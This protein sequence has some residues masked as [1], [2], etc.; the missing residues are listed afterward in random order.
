[1]SD[2]AI[3]AFQDD[4]SFGWKNWARSSDGVNFSTGQEYNTNIGG[5][6]PVG[7]V[8]ALDGNYLALSRVG[9]LY[10]RTAGANP[11]TAVRTVPGTPTTFDGSDCCNPV[12][13]GNA[14][15]LATTSGV[16]VL[17]IYFCPDVT[18]DSFTLVASFPGCWSRTNVR[19]DYRNGEYVISMNCRSTDPSFNGFVKSSDGI[20][21][22][23]FGGQGYTGLENF[24]CLKLLNTPGPNLDALFGTNLTLERTNDGFL[25]FTTVYT[26]AVLALEELPDRRLVMSTQTKVYLSDS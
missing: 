25:T 22:E 6:N 11:P 3:W 15:V 12:F 23:A 4:T 5:A 20:N 13:V 1:L 24:R 10:I 26:G 18:S 17:D 21:W 14:C 9:A 2:G 7:T 8:R 16:S 19:A